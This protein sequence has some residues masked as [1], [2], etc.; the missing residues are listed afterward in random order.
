MIPITF[1]L[2]NTENVREYYISSDWTL[3]E[4]YK[5]LRQVISSDFNINMNEIELIDTDISYKRYPGVRIENYPV[6]KESDQ[7]YLRELWGPRMDFLGMYIRK[8]TMDV[9]ECCVCLIDNLQITTHHE[10][11]HKFCNNCYDNCLRH[12]IITCPICRSS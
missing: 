12:N 1:K 10:C 3:E 9:G 7:T 4:L 5:N 2:V 8:R 11:V 6:L